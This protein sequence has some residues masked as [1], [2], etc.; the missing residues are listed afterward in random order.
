MASH[1]SDIDQILTGWLLIASRNSCF[2]QSMTGAIR[3]EIDPLKE[4]TVTFLLYR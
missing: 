3:H 1:L 2:S 4:S